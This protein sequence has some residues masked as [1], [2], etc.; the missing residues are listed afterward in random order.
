MSSRLPGLYTAAVAERRH[1]VA[2][3]A[4]LE[5]DALD[6]LDEGLTLDAADD[7]IENV[8]GRYALP[9]AVATNFTVDGVDALVPMVVEEPSVVAAASNGARMARAGGGFTAVVAP[10]IVTGQIQITHIA[11]VPAAA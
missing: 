2:A 5:P 4:G 9:F 8:L 3:A 1:R 6:A 7:M 11:D 10:A